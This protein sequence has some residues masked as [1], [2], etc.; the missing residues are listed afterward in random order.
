MLIATVPSAGFLDQKMAKMLLP[1]AELGHKFVGSIKSEALTFLDCLLK[2][3]DYTKESPCN[4]Q[5]Y[6]RDMT[7][8]PSIVEYFPVFI[9]RMPG[10]LSM[11]F[12]LH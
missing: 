8:E 1:F 9:R 10:I 2:Q 6:S 4:H 7:L 12:F 5:S 11:T 3:S